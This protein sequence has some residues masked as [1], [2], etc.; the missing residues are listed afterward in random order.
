MIYTNIA[1]PNNNNNRSTF[2]N[3]SFAMKKLKFGLTDFSVCFYVLSI[4]AFDNSI[5]FYIACALLFATSFVRML[6][7]NEIIKVHNY[8]V[9]LLFFILF[10]AIQAFFF[11]YD[12][13]SAMNRLIVVILNMGLSFFIFDYATDD[14]HRYLL[15][16]FFIFSTF[17]LF[18][19]LFFRD[20]YSLFSSRFSNQT[21]QPLGTGIKYNAN[22]VVRSFY[23]SCIFCLLILFK[24]KGKE[25]IA[26]K[27]VYSL[28]FMLFLFS[29]IMTGSRTGIAIVLLSLFAFFLIKSKSVFQFFRYVIL[30]T[31]IGIIF[32]YLI[33]NVGFL[34]T[35]VGSR[36]EVL[37]N[38][39]LS[40]GDFEYRT[41]AFTRDSMIETGIV[42]FAQ[43][44]L[45]GYGL[46]NYKYVSGFS[47]Y[48]HN[49]FIEILVSCGLIGFF[50]FY[51]PL[52]VMVVRLFKKKNKSLES[53][54]L[55]AFL[56]VSII[57][58]FGYVAYLQRVSLLLYALVA[59]ITMA[60]SNRENT[61][62]V[63]E[64]AI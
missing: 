14:N 62:F 6:R 45:V 20:P 60:S 30:I 53:I 55:L 47:V 25:S 24:Q 4:V 2:S 58:Q 26:L 54:A 5:I 49:N 48:S 44:P 57:C 1:S 36:F 12:T 10:N 40:G 43:K 37:I 15:Y 59:S 41:S 11:A 7:K 46:D 42:L 61:T 13:H 56:I 29:T 17:L 63:K 28:L 21:P 39:L 27:I 22:N 34:Y 19:Y 35:I 33:M 31:I 51:V 38:G 9:F 3:G 23:T 32:Y 18:T 16:K 52:F 64:R 8:F 50:L